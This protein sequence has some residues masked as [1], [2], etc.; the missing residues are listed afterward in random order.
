MLSN[1]NANKFKRTQRN[2][3]ER[4]FG[5][6]ARMSKVSTRAA[7]AYGRQL[8]TNW[9]QTIILSFW[10]KKMLTTFQILQ[11]HIEVQL[12]SKH[13]QVNNKT[14]QAAQSKTSGPHINEAVWTSTSTLPFEG[15][16][17]HL[18]PN[19]PP[20]GSPELTKISALS[21]LSPLL[22]LCW[23]LKHLVEA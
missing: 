2:M 1:A 4:I 23:G 17:A 9:I 11:K 10:L 12:F 8:E 21:T 15:H 7:A 14:A 16:N 20:N 22:R 3:K 6:K 5:K 13:L 18:G 19:S